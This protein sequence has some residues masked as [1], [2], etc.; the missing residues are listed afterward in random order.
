MEL[1]QG[2][3][4]RGDSLNLNMVRTH[5]FHCEWQWRS[6]E[7]VTQQHNKTRI[8]IN[9]NRTRI[10]KGTGIGLGHESA[11]L[12]ESALSVFRMFIN[13]QRAELTMQWPQTKTKCTAHV[14][15]E[16]SFRAKSGHRGQE[17][18]VKSSSFDWPGLCMCRNG[19]RRNLTAHA[20]V[21]ILEH[22]E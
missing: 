9:R 2:R 13:S 21:A 5:E 6:S 15:E 14:R 1:T 16:E 8:R 7:T 4:D 3:V 10:R 20:Q 22:R 12:V 19:H 11:L 18:Q 17:T